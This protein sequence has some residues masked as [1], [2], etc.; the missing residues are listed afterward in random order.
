MTL[1]GQVCWEFAVKPWSA[2]F[3]GLAQMAMLTLLV[4]DATGNMFIHNYR[5]MAQ[6]SFGQFLF[7]T[8]N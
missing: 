1:S 6:S 4:W 5:L 7:S 3:A 2:P 8:L